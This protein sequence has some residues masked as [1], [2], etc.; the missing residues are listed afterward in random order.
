MRMTFS[1]VTL[2]FALAFLPKAGAAAPCPF[3]MV[4]VCERQPQAR[5]PASPSRCHCESP[6]GSPTWGGKAEIHRK[7]VPTVKPNKPPGPNN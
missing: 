6:P 3:P 5:P 2:A 7:N 1:F 4:Q